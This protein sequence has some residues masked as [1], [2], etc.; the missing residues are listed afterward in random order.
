V[1]RAGTPAGDDGNTASDHQEDGAEC[2]GNGVEDAA[3]LGQLLDADGLDELPL[4]RDAVDL[5]RECSGE[6]L[7][8]QYDD[9]LDD[10]GDFFD[11]GWA[12]VHAGLDAVLRTDVRG[13]LRAWLGLAVGA[14]LRR[15]RA[16]AVGGHVAAVGA[17]LHR[18]RR[19]RRLFAT[20]LHPEHLV[21]DVG[22]LG[23]VGVDRQLDV[24]SLLRMRRDA[25]ELEHVRL[26]CV[27]ASL[28]AAAGVVILSDE[29]ANV[30]VDD[31]APILGRRLQLETNV[32][33]ELT[34]VEPVEVHLERAADVRLVVGVVVE[35]DAVELDGAVVAGRVDLLDVHWGAGLVGCRGGTL[36]R[37]QFGGAGTSLGLGCRRGIRGCDGS[38]G[39]RGGD[40]GVL[41]GLALVDASVGFVGL[42]AV[43]V[44]VAV[45]ALAAAR[46]FGGRSGACHPRLRNEQ[47]NCCSSRCK[48]TSHGRLLFSRG[49]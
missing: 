41:L 26:G 32:S 44:A 23:S 31:D 38:R 15:G 3:G 40:G 48:Q 19:G 25:D 14:L 10:D 39:R 18:R 42:A 21:L 37:G 33:V 11:D 2:E 16:L 12:L 27:E 7:T 20:S 36:G 46:A 8:L 28:A 24:Y 34:L 49:V 47:Q 9:R 43:A 22:T 35:R 5:G 45:G 1:L 17:L 6:E 13:G 29:G 30:A 4:E